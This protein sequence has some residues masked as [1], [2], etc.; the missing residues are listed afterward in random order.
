MT[1]PIHAKKDAVR[2]PYSPPQIAEYGS[3]KDVT[4]TVG[5]TGAR[6]GGGAKSANKTR[7]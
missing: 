2:T 5:R 1:D 4:L 3:L 6:D 7:L